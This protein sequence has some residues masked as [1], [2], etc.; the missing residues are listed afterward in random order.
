MREIVWYGVCLCLCL[1]VSVSVSVCACVCVRTLLRLPVA[2]AC[3]RGAVAMRS[4]PATKTAAT[5]RKLQE[6]FEV[7][8]VHT[9]AH[10]ASPYVVGRSRRSARRWRSWRR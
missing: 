4:L 2:H 9:Y 6:Q 8:L 5:A 3:T 10:I 7:G 1:S